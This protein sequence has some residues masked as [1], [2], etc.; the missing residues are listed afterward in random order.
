MFSGVSGELL[1]KLGFPSQ[2]GGDNT[3]TAVVD[4]I[5]TQMKT[6]LVGGKKK[7]PKGSAA[8]GKGR[9]FLPYEKLT[10]TVLKEKAKERKI[11]GYSKLNKCQLID[12]L[13][14]K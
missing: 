1:N 14:K 11:P 6:P 3:S 8:H 4:H 12:A 5:S 7:A 13:R 2:K 9:A 10:L